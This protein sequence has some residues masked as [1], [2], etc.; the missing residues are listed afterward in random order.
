MI[1]YHVSTNLKHN[2]KFYPRVPD[3]R[4]QDQEDSRTPRISVANTIEDCF[5]AIPNGGSRLDELNIQR[6]GYYLIYRID[7]EK[8][9]IPNDS[10]VSSDELYEKD[11]VRDA[12]FTNEHWLT[13]PFEV[14][15]ED[16]FMIKL[17]SWEE[18]SEDVI[19]HS[20]YAI[21]DEKYEGDYCRAY[22]EVYGELTPSASRIH[23][24]VYFKETVS[25]DEEVTL[26]FEND[27]EKTMILSY[28]QD[29]L[30]ADVQDV[31]YDEIKVIMKEEANLRR[32]FMN[33]AD[34]A[35]LHI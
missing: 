16:R 26:Y 27:E 2:G 21:A 1:F 25:K 9:R 10:I 13:V 35:L 11:L 32:L 15:E 23:D 3:C 8:L 14:P 28:I 5:T 4:H 33:H 34:V 7:T 20:L 24:L 18:A 22:E 6:R 30:N 19:P 29:H 31:F 17:I 12:G